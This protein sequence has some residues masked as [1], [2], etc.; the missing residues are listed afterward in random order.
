[1]Q[2]ARFPASVE[3]EGAVSQAASDDYIQEEPGQRATAQ[4]VL[5]QVERFVSPGPLIDLGCWTGFLLAEAR[6]RGWQPLGIEPSEFASAFARDRL[7]LEVRTEALERAEL[8]AGRF[9]A[10]VM[11]DVIEHLLDPEAALKRVGAALDSRGVACL[12]LPDAGSLIARG[13]GTRW[14]SVIPT[15]IQYFTRHSL[16]T[17]LERCGYRVLYVS[18]QPKAFTVRY[19]LDRIGGYSPVAARALV[20]TASR[21]GLADRIWAPDFR[22]RMLVIARGPAGG[23]GSA[24]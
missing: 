21:A 18:T 11:G 24:D 23:S 2:L 13:M 10:A 17:L 8:P 1:M 4:H 5:T 3:L 16:R 14:W 19:Y 12:M 7:G 20:G 9:N 6:D 22:D 15:H